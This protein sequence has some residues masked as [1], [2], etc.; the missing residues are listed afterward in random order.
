MTRFNYSKS[1]D[2]NQQCLAAVPRT[3]THTLE[4]FLPKTD[5]TIV[6]MTF[7]DATPAAT[8]TPEFSLINGSTFLNG[9]PADSTQKQV[10]LIGHGQVVP[11]GI[12]GHITGMGDSQ[13]QGNDILYDLEVTA[14]DQLLA[15]GLAG[16]SLLISSLF[17]IEFHHSSATPV[18]YS[19]HILVG[20]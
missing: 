20:G 6:E 19:A 13:G 7:E 11:S 1:S 9:K 14:E 5:T 2:P 17:T 16:H 4:V 3:E 8:V 12:I 18:T 15:A 10:Y